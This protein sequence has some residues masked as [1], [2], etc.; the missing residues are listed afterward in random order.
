MVIGAWSESYP[1]ASLWYDKECVPCYRYGSEARTDGYGCAVALNAEQAVFIAAVVY[2]DMVGDKRLTQRE[3]QY[4]CNEHHFHI[5]CSQ[6][7]QLA[8]LLSKISTQPN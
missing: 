1:G 6:P 2:M 5:D 7:I 8:K 3:Q 4:P